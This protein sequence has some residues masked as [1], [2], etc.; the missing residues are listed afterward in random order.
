MCFCLQKLR[1]LKLLR[2]KHLSKNRKQVSFY[3]K[4]VLLCYLPNAHPFHQLQGY[5]APH[6]PH[7][8]AKQQDIESLTIIVSRYLN[9]V[10]FAVDEFGLI[11][12]TKK[13][14]D[15]LH[16]SSTLSTTISTALRSGYV[17]SLTNI[18]HS[19]INFVRHVLNCTSVLYSGG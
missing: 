11:F 16:C 9:A 5:A 7:L 15:F 17:I 2:Q 19:L 6:Q 3:Y 18:L 12:L 10:D 14:N 13:I 8:P 4:K 1:L